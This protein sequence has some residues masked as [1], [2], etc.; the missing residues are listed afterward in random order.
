[1]K[2]AQGISINVIIV[3]AIALVV[4][5]VLLVVFT[6]RMGI[7]GGGLTD[8]TK[9]VKCTDSAEA[10]G[11]GGRWDRVCGFGEVEVFGAFTDSNTH[12]DEKCCKP[13]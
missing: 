9:Q 12:V 3:A 7:W 1:M 10:G 5:V 4:L 2:K 6:G 11:P 8:A 13:E